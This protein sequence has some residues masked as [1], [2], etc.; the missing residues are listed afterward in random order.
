MYGSSMLVSLARVTFFF[1][2]TL[3]RYSTHTCS[4]AMLV[5]SDTPP[6][7]PPKKNLDLFLYE[8]FG[9]LSAVEIKR[10]GHC[11]FKY[12]FDFFFFWLFFF[13]LFFYSS[14]GCQKKKIPYFTHGSATSTIR[15]SM[16]GLPRRYVLYKA[17]VCMSSSTVLSNTALFFFSELSSLETQTNHQKTQIR[18]L[19]TALQAPS[20]IET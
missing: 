2:F 11:A 16:D 1:F 10:P 9:T 15:E 8:Y 17:W 5:I 12:G 4:T 13:F 14:F 6:P 19:P 3:H 18:T 7:P 20:E